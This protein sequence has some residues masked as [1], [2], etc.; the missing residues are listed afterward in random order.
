MFQ[1]WS[2]PARQALE[3]VR[4]GRCCDDGDED[5]AGS[6][7]SDV[8]SLAVRFYEDQASG[9]SVIARLFPRLSTDSTMT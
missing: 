1:A 6:L 2:A 8:V 5:C 9:S 3:V 7:V 4:S